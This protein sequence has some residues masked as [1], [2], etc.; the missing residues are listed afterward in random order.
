MFPSLPLSFSAHEP[1]IL[2][3][4]LKF[5]HTQEI[6]MVQVPQRDLSAFLQSFCWEEESDRPFIQHASV[7]M[8]LTGNVKNQG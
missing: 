7:L 6:V 2:C 4:E 3:W 5:G 1:Q 8:D